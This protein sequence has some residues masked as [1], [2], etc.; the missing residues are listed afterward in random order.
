MNPSLQSE[1]NVGSLPNDLQNI[2]YTKT[3]K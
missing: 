2:K 3:N 1:N